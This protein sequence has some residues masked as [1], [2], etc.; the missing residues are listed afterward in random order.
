MSLAGREGCPLP[1]PPR[2]GG[3]TTFHCAANTLIFSGFEAKNVKASGA[4]P[5]APMGELTA[6]PHTPLLVSGWAPPPAAPPTNRPPYSPIPRSATDRYAVQYYSK[7]WKQVILVLACFS[8]IMLCFV[9]LKVQSGWGSAPELTA[10]PH[11]PLLVVGVVSCPAL[12]LMSPCPPPPPAP[13]SWIRP[14]GCAQ[15]G[16][17]DCRQVLRHVSTQ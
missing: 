10:L 7:V 2:G 3:G 17:S 1:Y 15:S 16:Q 12:A 13:K 8:A 11:T 9:T 4:P 14:W 6:L 5:Q